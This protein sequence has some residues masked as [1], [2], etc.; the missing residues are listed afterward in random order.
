MESQQMN[1]AVLRVFPERRSSAKSVRFLDIVLSLSKA[2]AAVRTL[3][4]PCSC[5]RMQARTSITADRHRFTV[6]SRGPVLL[7]SFW[8]AGYLCMLSEDFRKFSSSAHRVYPASAALYRVES[9]SN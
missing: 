1:A 2:L 6:C 8:T 5:Q 9:L 7:V 4:H 3:G